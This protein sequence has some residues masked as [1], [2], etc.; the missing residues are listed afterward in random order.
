MRPTSLLRIITCCMNLVFIRPSDQH[1]WLEL[2]ICV[3]NN[4]HQSLAH[5]R[6]AAAIITLDTSPLTSTSTLATQREHPSLVSEA[7]LGASSDY[8]VTEVVSSH[9]TGVPIAIVIELWDIF[10]TITCACMMSTISLVS[11]KTVD[12]LLTKELSI[13]KTRASYAN[14]NSDRAAIRLTCTQYLINI[15]I[16]TRMLSHRPRLVFIRFSFAPGVILALRTHISNPPAAVGRIAVLNV[17]NIVSPPIRWTPSLLI[18]FRRITPWGKW[19]PWVRLRAGQMHSPPRSL[20]WR[21][22]HQWPGCRCRLCEVSPQP[23]TLFRTPLFKLSLLIDVLAAI[24]SWVGPPQNKCTYIPTDCHRS[25]LRFLL[26]HS[27]PLRSSQRSRES[28]SPKCD[29]EWLANKEI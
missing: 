25:H 20:V 21:E 15:G 6:G 13:L 23:I 7:R 10:Q 5:V 28:T 8:G 22:W 27:T 24:F 17:Y 1:M 3:N 11:T 19:K 29:S 12:F 16:V 9:A 14:W 18:M 4:S 26:A 2:Y